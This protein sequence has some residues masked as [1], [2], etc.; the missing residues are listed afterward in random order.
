[1]AVL[2]HGHILSSIIGRGVQNDDSMTTAA[3]ALNL[4]SATG[5]DLLPVV[6]P[7]DLRSRVSDDQTVE[8]G[9]H[10][11]EDVFVLELADESRREGH[12]SAVLFPVET[13]NGPGTNDVQGALSSGRAKLVRG[14][15]RVL[16][17]VFGTAES[18]YVESER[19]RDQRFWLDSI[20]L[21]HSR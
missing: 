18:C 20:K 17:F 6:E 1:M 2:C 4:D 16:A 12:S 21:T 5:D 10:V 13:A 19:G 15:Q 3:T 14:F 7:F 11:M 8:D 9:R